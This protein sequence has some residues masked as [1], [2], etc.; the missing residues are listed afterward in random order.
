MIAMPIGIRQFDITGAPFTGDPTK[1]ND[2][3]AA[4]CTAANTNNVSFLISYGTHLFKC[5]QEL[6]SDPDDDQA[7]HYFR[8]H[9]DAAVVYTSMNIYVVKTTIS[10]TAAQYVALRDEDKLKLQKYNVAMHVK[11]ANQTLLEALRKYFLIENTHALS[12]QLQQALDSPTVK[13]AIAMDFSDWDEVWAH[14]QFWHQPAVRVWA[15]I[16]DIFQ[17]KER[18]SINSFWSSLCDAAGSCNQQL[19]K[20]AQ[21]S[22]ADSAIE[23]CL[24]SLKEACGN[25]ADRMVDR[26]H[27][28]IRMHMF[29]D[30]AQ[31]PTEGL[32]WDQALC[33]VVKA[34]RQGNFTRK[35]TKDASDGALSL[36]AQGSGAYQ[37]ADDA[38]NAVTPPR[39]GAHKVSK[40]ACPM[41]TLVNQQIKIPPRGITLQA[42]MTARY[43]AR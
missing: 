38:S 20:P 41:K 17:G 7:M 23:M 39:N 27:A 36:I 3:K 14:Q 21:Y 29:R 10:E 5:R 30:L 33:D 32:A 15:D 28:E 24:K 16:L 11:R 25:D 43:C 1:W 2:I 18:S 8:E 22:D 4:V 34:Q 42:A 12:D 9:T 35:T 19:R 26:I 37:T 13:R 40:E 6:N 31:K